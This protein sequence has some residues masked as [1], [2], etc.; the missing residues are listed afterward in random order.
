MIIT[1]QNGSPILL[2]RSHLTHPVHRPTSATH[3]LDIVLHAGILLHG[4]VVI[5]S[6]NEHGKHNPRT[7]LW[8]Y[9]TDRSG[10]NLIIRPDQWILARSQWMWY[11]VLTLTVCGY[12]RRNFRP[13]S[14][15][16]MQLL[17]QIFRESCV[18]KKR[19]FRPFHRGCV[20]SPL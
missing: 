15:L 14:S 12:F 18:R 2:T 19:Y 13:N 4:M 6:A 17:A 20:A 10:D 3:W 16:K 1:F 8:T 9:W 11:S 7:D 5:I